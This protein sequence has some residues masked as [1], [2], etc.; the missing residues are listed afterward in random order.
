MNELLTLH[1]SAKATMGERNN[2]AIPLTYPSDSHAV[3]QAVRERIL[4]ADYSH[5]ALVAVR[6]E[7]AY[8][9][10]NY[11]ISANLAAIRDE[12][13]MYTL[14]LDEQGQIITDA[15]LLCDDEQYLILTEWLTAEQLI[16]LIQQAQTQ[17]ASELT[18][19]E[20][21]D[22]R[23]QQMGILHLE[24]P[25]S[26]ELLAEIYGIDIVGLPFQEHMH[27]DEVIVFR[28]GKHGEFSYKIIATFSQLAEI[29][30][31]CLTLG[32][33]YQL[34]V[35]GLDYQQ[36]VRLENPCWQPSVYQSQLT[37][38][39]SLQLQWM[40]GYEKTDFI[41]KTALEARLADGV[42][43]RVVGIRFAKEAP[44]AEQVKVN[45]PLCC[46]QQQIGQLIHCGYSPIE[47]AYL[48]LACLDD[49]YAYADISD[50]QIVSSAGELACE[51]RPVPFIRNYSFLVNPVEHSYVDPQRPKNLLEQLAQQQA[52]QQEE[53]QASLTEQN[54]VDAVASSAK[55]G[56][57]EQ[58]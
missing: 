32:A 11:V 1:L 5:F 3:Y 34:V 9:L 12:Q 51:T 30:Q 4:L 37:C 36:L 47:Q 44:F 41:G 35:G 23:Q 33:K 20:L 42:T 56:N 21:V 24:G 43:Q 13:A 16:N 8:Q 58:F 6:G 10:L 52:S 55:Q 7:D 39:I 17:L 25:Y 26:W 15:Y 50:Y 38:P 49:A 53:Q 27:F 14:L 31:Q 29:W 19:V 57:E 46:Q 40:V 2:L 45:D 22:L 28:S 54:A 18:Q 48:G